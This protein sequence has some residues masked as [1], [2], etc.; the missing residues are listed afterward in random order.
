MLTRNGGNRTQENLSSTSSY[1]VLIVLHQLDMN[2]ASYILGFNITLCLDQC[3]HE[4]VKG[5]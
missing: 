2:P 4:Q 1:I 3:V 5:D